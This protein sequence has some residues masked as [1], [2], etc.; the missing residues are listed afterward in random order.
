MPSDRKLV[1]NRRN[2]QRS[3]GPRDTSRSRLNALTHGIFADEAFI[4]AGAGRE[5]EAR[6]ANLRDALYEELAPEG[7][8]ETLLVDKL[9]A[10]V[11]RWRRVLRF[12]TAAIRMGA[13]VATDDWEGQERNRLL[14]AAD[15]EHW[16]ATEDLQILVEPLEQALAALDQP[17]PLTAWPELWHRAF[18]VAESVF[19][20]RIRKVLGLK[21]AWEEHDQFSREAVEQVIAGACAETNSTPTAFWA[22]VKADATQEYERLRPRWERRRLALERHQLLRSLPDDKSLDKVQ[23]YEAHLSRQFYKAHHELQRLQAARLGLR[24]QVPMAL[25]ITIS[26]SG[27]GGRNES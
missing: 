9:I 5:D 25:D 10:M 2:A 3:T 11:W 18:S 12:E 24:P 19:H 8:M 6:F 15:G 13:D 16:E 27:D 1:A 7:A 21:K 26:D 4:R 23:R 20:V 17:D 14:F 22:A